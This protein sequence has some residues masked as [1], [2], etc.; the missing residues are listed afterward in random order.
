MEIDKGIDQ[1]ILKLKHSDRNQNTVT[2]DEIYYECLIR[3]NL[4]HEAA[5]EIL[6]NNRPNLVNFIIYSCLKISFF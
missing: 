1:R 4:D 6:R 5:L 2:G 3:A